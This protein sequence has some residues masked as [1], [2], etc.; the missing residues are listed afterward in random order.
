MGTVL[1]SVATIGLAVG[2]SMYYEW[3]LGLLALAFTPFILLATF[4]EQRLM[5]VEN[6][7]Q[8][9]TLQKSIKVCM[10]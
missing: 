2:L 8:S 1:Q 3:R 7:S 10:F 5:N 6:Q 9:E 4:G